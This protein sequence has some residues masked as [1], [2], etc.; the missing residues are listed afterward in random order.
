MF[1]A[2]KTRRPWATVII[3][4]FLSPMIGMFYLG[5]GRAGLIYLLLEIAAALVA[6]AAVLAGLLNLDIRSAVSLLQYTVILPGCIHGYV[7]ARRQNGLVPRPWFARWYSWLPFYIAPVVLA[8]AVR[9]FC[10]EPFIIPSQSSLP[11]LEVGD[12]LFVSKFAYGYSRYSVPFG[13]PIFSGRIFASEPKR[14]DIVVFKWPYD[15]RTDYI[16]R[17]V[18]LPGDRIQMREG[19]LV[20][21]GQPVQR[22]RIEDYSFM[23][24][25][26]EAKTVP[27]YRET[28][29][30]GRS[31]R[32]LDRAPTPLD[33]T[34]V[35]VVPTGHYFVLGDNRDNSADSRMPAGPVGVGLVPAEN[36]VGRASLI[37]RSGRKQQLEWV[38]PQ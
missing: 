26:G 13:P 2:F 33:N 29:P 16:K 12:Y 25:N 7:I 11:T 36:L 24:A 1:T 30:D 34:G 20:I 6:V 27:Q 19:V 5:R 8:V 3:C 28:L 32:V 9:T 31:Y 38:H 18:G 15:N 23:E 21:N 17:L 10:F 4:F 22:T 35:Y 37:L 14:G